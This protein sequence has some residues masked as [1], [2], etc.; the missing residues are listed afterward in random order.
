[1]MAARHLSNGAAPSEQ[2]VT[3]S[4]LSTSLPSVTLTRPSALNSLTHDMCVSLSSAFNSYATSSAVRAVVLRGEGRAFCAG[5]DVVSLSKALQKDPPDEGLCYDFF[6][7]E[8]EADILLAKFEKPIV[9]LWDGI[10]MG[11][12]V[13]ISIHAPFRIATEKTLF[14]MPET[15]IGL[16]PDV[17]A[18]FFLSRMDGG[19]GLYLG[20][21]S[22]R[23]AGYA[24]YQAGVAS[25][26]VP[27]SQIPALVD[28]LAAIKDSDWPTEQKEALLFIDS[29]VRPFESAG[30]EPAPFEF[31][32]A[33]RE[34]IDRIFSVKKK[35]RTLAHIL[36][37]LGKVE[38]ELKPWA[39]ETKKTIESR[40]PT[41]CQVTVEQ[42][43]RAKNMDIDQVFGM[44]WSLACACCTP[45]LH[46]DFRDGVASLLIQKSKTPP[47]WQSPSPDLDAYFSFS[48]PSSLSSPPSKPFK[49]YPHAELPLSLP[50]E[51][52]IAKVVRGETKTSGSYALTEEEIIQKLVKEWKQ[53]EGVEEKVR[54]VLSR[55]TKEGEEKT[56]KWVH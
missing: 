35:D 2:H 55:K 7:T 53:K 13:G 32:G 1:M 41:S 52:Y 5:G 31:V 25:H 56:R 34:A 24:A 43:R 38:G 49:S 6:K 20:L 22:A 9:A 8:Y 33:K 17:G 23:L 18:S 44:D 48:T 16:F 4:S 15:T 46:T 47:K 14:A 39:E 21:T 11:G 28:R 10:V 3:T 42:Y 30:A 26:F 37:D 12:G 19:L 45:N 51:D 50:S 40:S 54:E 36:E 29:I 27:S